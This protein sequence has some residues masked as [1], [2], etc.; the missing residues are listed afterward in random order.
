MKDLRSLSVN[1]YFDIKGNIVKLEYGGISDL[2]HWTIK[3]DNEQ[4][5]IEMK[6]LAEFHEI[7]VSEIR[8]ISQKEYLDSEEDNDLEIDEDEDEF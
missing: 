4:A 5:E 8:R 3:K 1:F 2:K 7:D 6:K